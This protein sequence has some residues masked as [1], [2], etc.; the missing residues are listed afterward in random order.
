MLNLFQ[1]LQVLSKFSESTQIEECNQELR[2][3]ETSSN[4][5]V[6]FLG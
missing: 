1:K 2:N 4:T 3:T 6:F 5:K